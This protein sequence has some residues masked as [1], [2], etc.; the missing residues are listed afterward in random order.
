[1]TNNN[2]VFVIHIHREAATRYEYIEDYDVLSKMDM[3]NYNYYII[4]LLCIIFVVIHGKKSKLDYKIRKIFNG[5]YHT[6]TTK[7]C[8]K[9]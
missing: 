2:F 6:S 4:M 1:M 8:R 3:I 9:R 7:Y 5:M